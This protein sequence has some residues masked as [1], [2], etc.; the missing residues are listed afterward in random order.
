[1]KTS[2]TPGPWNKN[3]G[4][5]WINASGYRE[6]RVNGKTTKEHRHIMEQ[7]L[8]RKLLATELVHHKNGIKTDNRIENLEIQEWDEHTIEHHKGS[9]RSEYTKQTMKVLANFREENK[10]LKS[11]NMELLEALKKAQRLLSMA[12]TETYRKEIERFL[13][14][15]YAEAVQNAC[16]KDSLGI[17]AAIKKATE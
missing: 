17:D 2:H 14:G 10:S 3:S 13:S 1:M 8:G 12:L 15:G 16:L 4:N 9:T 7:H 11:I 6:I 5:G